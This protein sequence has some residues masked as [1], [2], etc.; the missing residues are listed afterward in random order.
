MSEFSIFLTPENYKYL[1]VVINDKCCQT[2]S[3]KHKNYMNK[4]ETVHGFKVICPA[5]SSSSTA[6]HCA[7]LYA[8]L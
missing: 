1:C 2:V 3:A 5:Y 7:F 8:N 4:K 6:Q